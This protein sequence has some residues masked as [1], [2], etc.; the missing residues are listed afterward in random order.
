MRKSRFT[1]QQI[2]FA[3]RQAEQGVG[4]GEL[5]RKLGVSEQTI[6]QWKKKYAGMGVTEMRQLKL[7]EEE[8]ARLKRVCADLLLDKQILQEVLAKKF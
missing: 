8:N 4:T 5:A 2:A 6:Y 3:M 1:D 7:L